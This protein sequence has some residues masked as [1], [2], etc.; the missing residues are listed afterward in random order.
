MG[1]AP[2]SAHAHPPGDTYQGSTA[3]QDHED[4]EGLEPVVLDNLKAGPAECPP[5][6]PTALGDVHVEER[7]AL[8][9][10]WGR[11]GARAPHHRT[12]G[13]LQTCGQL[14]PTTFLGSADP[15]LPHL[16]HAAFTLPSPGPGGKSVSSGLAP[17]GLG[18]PLSADEAEEGNNLR[19]AIPKHWPFPSTGSHSGPC[20]DSARQSSGASAAPTAPA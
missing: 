8:H 18:W 4:D 12:G 3:E 5:H 1:L 19:A 2:A 15:H 16:S 20:G 9:A 14:V 17:E 13:C 7:A 10:G 11:E 6:L